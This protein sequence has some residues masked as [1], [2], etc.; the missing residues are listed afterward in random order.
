MASLGKKFVQHVVPG[1]VKPVRVL[2]N[3]FIAFIFAILAIMAVPSAYRHIKNFDGDPPSF[4]RAILSCCFAVI[5][6]VFAVGSY[7]RA[8]KISRS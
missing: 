8:R 7:L 5:M 2:W 1:V 3:D 6:I 4:F